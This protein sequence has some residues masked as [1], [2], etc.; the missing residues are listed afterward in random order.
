MAGIKLKTTNMP[1][2]IVKLH[3]LHKFLA[4]INN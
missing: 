1:T 3:L 2:S 4:I